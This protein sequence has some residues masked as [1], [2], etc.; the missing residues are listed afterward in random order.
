MH[1]F[2]SLESHASCKINPFLIKVLRVLVK[3]SMT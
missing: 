3:Y 1:Y 2:Q